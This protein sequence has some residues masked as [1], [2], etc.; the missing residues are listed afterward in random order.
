MGSTCSSLVSAGADSL[1]I[2]IECHLSNNL[3]TILIVGFASKTVNEAKDRLRGAFANSQLELPRR[4]ITINLAPADIPKADSGLDLAIAASI[5]IADGSVAALPANQA[6]IGELGLD[7]SI[8]PVRGIIGKLLAGRRHGLCSYFVPISNLEQASLVPGLE[9]LPVGSLRQLYEHLTGKHEIIPVH[10]DARAT[11]RNL[12]AA[13]QPNADLPLVSEIVGQDSAKRALVIAAAGGHNILFSGPPGTGKSMLAKALPGLLPPLSH[14]EMLEVT[15]LSSLANNDYE[16][17]ATTRPIRAPH[18]SASHTAMV[19]GGTHLKPGEI[20]LSH[21]GILL[22]DEFPEFNRQTLEALRQPLEDRVITVVRTRDSAEYPANFILAATANP[23]PCGYYG[24]HNRCKC[25][26]SDLRRYQSKL[27]G[28]ILDRIDLCCEV[29]EVD[30]A[31]LLS[32]HQPVTDTEL[33]EQ[34]RQARRLQAARYDSSTLLNGDMS[35]RQLRQF[36]KLDRAARITLQNAALRYGLSARGYM[37]TLKVARTIA[38]LAGSAGI[39]RDHISEALSYR[40]HPAVTG[41]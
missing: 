8:R 40:Q 30:H 25:T 14:E 24:H 21:R 2:D 19:G 22:L 12:T 23:C 37:R 41:V 31:K 32:S 13:D 1:V 39:C 27:S 10:S 17:L 11:A 7:G 36:A 16:R 18:H 3:P 34:I 35:N 15:H 29:Y 38:D 26:E 28:P 6:L 20:S 9:L 5:M 33:R 4:R